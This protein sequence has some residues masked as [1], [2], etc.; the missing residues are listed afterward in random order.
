MEQKYLLVFWNSDFSEIH[1]VSCLRDYIYHVCV[2]V[3][4]GRDLALTVILDHFETLENAEIIIIFLCL[5][6]IV[7]GEIETISAQFFAKWS[8]HSQYNIVY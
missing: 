1:K 5:V 6:Q 4:P 7:C 8:K 2:I 3:W